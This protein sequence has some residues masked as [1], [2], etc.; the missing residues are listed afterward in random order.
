MIDTTMI[1]F[2]YIHKTIIE[3]LYI[4]FISIKIQ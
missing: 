2:L 1:R 4:D 3:I